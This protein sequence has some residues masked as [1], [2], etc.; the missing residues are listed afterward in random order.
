MFVAMVG[1]LRS[2][3]LKTAN[4]VLLQ[5]NAQVLYCYKCCF[6]TSETSSAVL[7]Q[8]NAQ[9]LFHY[10]WMLKCRS[11]TS[12]CSSAVLLQ[13]NAQCSFLLQETDLTCGQSAT[14]STVCCAV[15]CT[16]GAGSPQARSSSG[17]S[18][19]KQRPTSAAHTLDAPKFWR[20]YHHAFFPTG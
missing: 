16:R 9:M 11:V 18:F 8:L 20:I 12:E 6:V 19:S 2:T 7:L 3:K 14:V 10:Q 1:F 15:E 17:R 13:V 4:S 5:V